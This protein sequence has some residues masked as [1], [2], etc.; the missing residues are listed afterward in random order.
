MEGKI[1]QIYL[2]LTEAAPRWNGD[3]GGE[4]SLTMI[5]G[6]SV[7]RR[8]GF[9][10]TKAVSLSVHHDQMFGGGRMKW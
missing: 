9:T 5:G 8:S 7:G 1:E 4:K 10:G 2:G 6:W 3:D